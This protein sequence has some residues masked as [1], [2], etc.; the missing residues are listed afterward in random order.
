MPIPAGKGPITAIYSRYNSTPQLLIRD[1]F[2]VRMNGTRCGGV[3]ILPPVEI[4]IDSLRKLYNNTGIVLSNYKIHGVVISSFPDSNMSKGSIYMQDESGRGINIYYGGTIAYKLGDSLSVDVTGD[5]LI[6]YKGILEVKKAAAKT[7]NVGT[8]KTVTPALVTLAQLTADMN[9]ASYKDRVYE[10]TLVKVNACTISG[11]PTTY[12]D[13]SNAGR[14]IT[15]ATGTF[16]LYCRNTTPYNAT[17]YAPGIV[18]ITGI[19]SK[20]NTNQLLIRK[21]SDIQ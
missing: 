14:T 4:K 5:S 13:A 9:N 17:N 16:I 20:Y 18:N 7:T 3:V 19:A 8:G 2:D 15:D 10:S 21:L 12:G 1:T 11:T 6:V